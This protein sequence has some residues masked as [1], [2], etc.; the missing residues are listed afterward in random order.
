MPKKLFWGGWI[1]SIIAL[2]LSVYLYETRLDITIYQN[3]VTY[4]PFSF[5]Q[6]MWGF[7]SWLG[8]DQVQI[9][10][11]IVAGIFYYKKS[12]YQMSRV[13]YISIIIFLMSGI[14]VQ[15]LKHIIGRPRPKMLPE[16]DVLWFELGARLHSIPSGHT[17]TTFAWLACLLPFYNLKIKVFLVVMA[18]AIGFSR[19]GI[20]AHYLSDVL[21]GAVLGYA[22]GMVLREKMNLRKEVF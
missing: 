11:C 14:L 9:F 20:G 17:M 1:L 22:T 4:A 10:I 18:C 21:M 15:V 6:D 8:E 16:Y 2:G 13:W 5:I 19:V 7:L 12:N 3:T